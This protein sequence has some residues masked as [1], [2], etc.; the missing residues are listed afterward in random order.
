MIQ[1]SVGLLGLGYLGKEVIR[2][3][4]NTL[5]FWA[6]TT[7]LND[8]DPQLRSQILLFEFNWGD[9]KS[10]SVIPKDSTKLVITIPPLSTIL[11]DETMRLETWCQWMNDNRPNLRN[12]IY[13]STIGVYPKKKGIWSEDYIFKADQLK[14]NIRLVTEDILNKYFNLNVIRPGGIYGPSR[15]IGQRVIKKKDSSFLQ[16]FV[17]RIHVS[18]LAGIVLTAIKNQMFPKILNA[19]DLTPSYTFEVIKWLLTQ[20]EFQVPR[21]INDFYESIIQ[22]DYK[23]EKTQER[24]ISNRLLVNGL[25]YKL[26]YPSYKEGF[27]QAV[28]NTN[29]AS[30][31]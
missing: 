12:V 13:I 26:K 28:E 8:V 17:Y 1:N 4:Q 24:I 9:K 25:G 21:D 22:P 16:R 5:P 27:R 6:T 11:E 23:I 14:S 3:S 2:I 20:N 29:L 10:W 18:D 31:N 15:L 30:F 19:V 7:Q